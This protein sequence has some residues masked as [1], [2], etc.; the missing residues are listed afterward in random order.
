MGVNVLLDMPGHR[1]HVGTVNLEK[2]DLLYWLAKSWL[3]G[4]Q[5]EI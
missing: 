1:R 5:I 3:E 2:H 4:E